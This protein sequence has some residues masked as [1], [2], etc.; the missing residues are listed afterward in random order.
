MRDGASRIE[1]NTRSF[2]RPARWK[3]IA[4][5]LLIDRPDLKSIMTIP[6]DLS[7]KTADDFDSPACGHLARCGE[8]R[9]Y[10]DYTRRHWA[11]EAAF[12]KADAIAARRRRDHH[13]RDGWRADACSTTR[14][15][16][17]RGDK[18]KRAQGR[19]PLAALSVRFIN[20]CAAQ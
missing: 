2:R 14:P 15:R 3:V 9:F 18:P 4:L 8:R 17:A 19:T 13:D 20:G 12:E 16:A 11:I 1:V 7:A 5:R 6:T 10:G